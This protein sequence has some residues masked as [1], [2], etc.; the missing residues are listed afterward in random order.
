MPIKVKK[1]SPTGKNPLDK[2][3]PKEIILNLYGGCS[4]VG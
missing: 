4:S 3:P 1:L 2:K